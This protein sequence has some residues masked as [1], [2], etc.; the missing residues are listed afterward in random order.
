MKLHNYMEDIINHVLDS[1]LSRRDDL[2]KCDKC[3][4]DIMALALNNLPPKYV[5]TDKGRIY[6]KLAELE[7]Q[8]KTDVIK[9]ITKAINVVKG[10]PQ[11]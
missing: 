6:T 4:L 11:H 8:S 10:K 1:T 9:E 5:V 3:R 7:L 2:C